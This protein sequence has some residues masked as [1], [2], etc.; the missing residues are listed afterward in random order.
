[1]QI[2][3]PAEKKAGEKERTAAALAAQAGD[4]V[5][6]TPLREVD[7]V[8]SYLYEIKYDGYR[9]RAVKAGDEV[10]L[11]TRGG[12]D[13]TARFAPVAAAVRKLHVREVVLDGEVCV[14]DARGRPSFQALQEWLAGE[15]RASKGAAALAYALFDVTWLDGKDLKDRPLEERRAALER[16]LEDAKPPLSFS[17][18]SVA[19]TPE[20]LAD[21]L[22]TVR[23]AGLEG[24]VAK[25]RGSKYLG[26]QSGVWRKLKFAQRQDC[27][28][29]GWVP[30]TNNPKVL[31][32]VVVAVVD[33]GKLRYAGRTGSGMDDATRSDMLR[34]LNAIKTEKSAVVVPRTPGAEWVTP[35]LVCEVEYA[36]WSRDGSLRSPVWIGLREDKTPD[37]CTV[38][39]PG[40]LPPP[41]VPDV[42]AELPKLSHPTKVLYPRD[43]ITKADILRYY[44]SVAPVLLPHLAGRPLTLQRWPDGIDDEEWY[45]HRAPYPLPPFVRTFV[46]EKRRRVIVD[47][48]E[49][50]AWLVNLAALTL[51][52][53]SCRVTDLARPEYA[54][55]DLD[56]GDTGWKDV[57]GVAHAVHAMLEGLSLPS[58]V[59]TSGKRG[60]HILVPLAHGPSHDDVFAFAERVALAVAKVMPD[61]ATT[62][63]QLPK[64]KGRLYVDYTVNGLGKSLVTAY[65]LRAIDGAPVSTPL[66]WNEVVPEVPPS[67]YTL[68]TVPSRVAR[69]G[70]L[71][72]SVLS[73]T[74][75]L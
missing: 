37:E 35:S 43:G 8:G 4:F 41:P 52:G 38:E 46:I 26:G 58:V 51:H 31:G 53:W 9:L 17:R 5:R 75:K 21:V 12:H 49:T 54:I 61:V 27:V 7:S 24:L 25:R 59:K 30:M 69:Y 72:A 10:L 6:P 11:I 18:A 50:L 64:R 70:D 65:S 63:R 66:R 45:Q 44:L 57:V 48:V 20:E 28:I 47:N 40:A 68:K 23:A 32:A 56:P 39:D 34:R 2:G 62:E 3:A 74:G 1:L 22:R 19:T 13:W 60:L 42:P 15:R 36:E 33:E 67:A 73:G 29:V 71:F 14:V 55:I 16:L